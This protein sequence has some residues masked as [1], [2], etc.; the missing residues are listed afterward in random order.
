MIERDDGA[1]AVPLLGVMHR[2]PHHAAASGYP[3]LAEFIAGMGSITGERSRTP[4]RVRKSVA[5]HMPGRGRNY[6]SLS[7]GKE[8]ELLGA[9]RGTTRG[10]AHYFDAERDACI[11][12]MLAGRF[13]WATSGS[14]HYPPSI[15]REVI[16]VRSV[17]RLDAAVAL[18]SNQVG[19]LADI[20]TDERVHLIPLGVDIDF[21]CPAGAGAPRDRQHVLLVGQHLRDFDVFADTVE[22]LKTRHPGLRVTA[23]LLSSYQKLIPKRSWISVRSGID[24]VELR[25][26][27]RS[28]SCLVLPLRDA[29]ACTA[30]VEA[31]ACGLPVVTTDVGGTVDYVPDG[32]GFR[33]GQGDPQ[34]MAD[35]V[36]E[37]FDAS[38]QELSDLAAVTRQHALQ[39]SLPVV[40]RQLQDLLVSLGSPPRPSL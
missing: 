18:A 35:A 34:A 39:Y 37:L 10:V 15:M 16:S 3:R 26:L 40:A 24:D 2:S 31:M 28:A 32:V 19:V 12:P 14:F 20:V 30:I 4:Y 21:F 8:L 33:C 6:N 1:A 23:V 27:Y 38:Q 29:A 25:S 36:S 7:L 11:G 9:I 5:S 22:L 13:G 17:G